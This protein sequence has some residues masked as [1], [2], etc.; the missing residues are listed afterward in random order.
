MLHE[1]DEIDDH[2]QIHGMKNNHLLY[3]ISITP[4][5]SLVPLKTIIFHYFPDLHPIHKNL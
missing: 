1:N 5:N 3:G 2:N 4:Y